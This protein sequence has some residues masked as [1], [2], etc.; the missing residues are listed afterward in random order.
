MS[1]DLIASGYCSL[2]HI[3]KISSTP[4]LGRTSLVI[5]D[6]HIEPYFG[7]CS[8]NVTYNLAKLGL[9]SRPIL[10][11]GK[12]YLKNGLKEYLEQANVDCEAVKLVEN[13][14]T[15]STYLVEDPH[16]DH[17]TLF[18]EGAMSPEHFLEYEDQWFEGARCALMTVASLKDNQAFLK[19]VKK[20]RVPLFLGMKMDSNAFP[21]T[22]LRECL[23]EVEVFFANE[24]EGECITDIYQLED[25]YSLFTVLP[26][27]K[28]MI[29]TKGQKGSEAA[30]MKD[31]K[32]QK[33]S[34]GIIESVKVV[35]TV[36]SGD[37]YI[38]GY[39]YGYLTGQNIETSMAYGAT[40]ASFVI[41][42]VG[43][44]TNSPNKEAF[45][46]RYQKHFSK[47]N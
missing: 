43:C 38:A 35:D 19:K 47:E 45:I 32:L 3:I 26:K 31:G 40:L 34:V 4:T 30:F 16:H 11:V 39:I 44:T 6:N 8:V 12:D 46:S 9:S 36:G 24:N 20:H 7:G 33:I 27:L 2:D 37:A 15:S 23:E 13:S 42:G 18:Y 22:F 17:I 28:V 1:V 10:R 21:K 41:E 14:T 5:N 29:I 25:I